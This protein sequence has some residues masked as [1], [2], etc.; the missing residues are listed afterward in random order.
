VDWFKIRQPLRPESEDFELNQDQ[1]MHYVMEAAFTTFY[2][3]RRSITLGEYKS[4]V[5][6]ILYALYIAQNRL[7]F[8]HN[9]M[10]MKNIL[11]NHLEE[12]KYIEIKDENYSWFIRHYSV[13]IC[14]FGLSRIKLPNGEVIFNP[15][16]QFKEGFRPEED[17]HKLA[18]ELQTVKI[19]NWNEIED[20]DSEKALLRDFKRRM[21]R[22]NPNLKSLLHH[23]FF[24][25]LQIVPPSNH[26][27]HSAATKMTLI[28]TP[29][30]PKTLTKHS[31]PSNKENVENSLIGQMESLSIAKNDLK[32]QKRTRNS[33]MKARESWQSQVSTPS[34]PTPMSTKIAKTRTPHDKGSRRVVH[35]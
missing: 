10:H 7:E 16:N 33:A 15:S 35:F 29:K 14:D 5:F 28:A 18:S 32:P 31:I 3:L 22:E 25:D 17:I 11:L 13:K 12:G 26:S 1:F 27:K 34:T 21:M 8:N 6:Q 30:V 9:D 4:I 19:N 23:K 2:N 24:G 20:S